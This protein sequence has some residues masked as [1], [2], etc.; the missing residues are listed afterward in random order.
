MQSPDRSSY[1]RIE[2]K[3]TSRDASSNELLG[4]WA[5]RSYCWANIRPK[6]GRER[7]AAGQVAS[8]VGM[9]ISA[10]YY[11]LDGVTADMRVVYS[12]SGN[13]A[14][15]TDWVYFEIDAVYTDFFERLETMLEVRQSTETNVG[16]V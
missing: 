5:L 12:P 16:I 3:S 1:I 10:D 13:Y 15:T 14:A 11:D 6:R 7:E 4:T 9:I 8:T 2:T